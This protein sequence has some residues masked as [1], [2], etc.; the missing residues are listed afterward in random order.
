MKH[1]WTL[2]PKGSLFRM[3]GPHYTP[4]QRTFM[5]VEYEKKRGHRDFLPEIIAD[6]MAR[7]PSQ[8]VIDARGGYI[9]D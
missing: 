1:P 9:E 3:V 4:P 2:F 8:S 6:F 5:A 7:W